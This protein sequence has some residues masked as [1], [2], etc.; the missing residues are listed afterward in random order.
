MHE[1]IKLLFDTF[2]PDIVIE[3]LT[4]FMTQARIERIEQVLSKRIHRVHIAVESP[5]DVHNGL[6]MVRTAEAMGVTHVHFV[7]AL[8]KKGQGR[9][10]TRGT[11]KWAHLKRHDTLEA[12]VQRQ[13]EMLLA[14]ACVDGQTSVEDLPVERPICFLFGNENTG[15][16]D[17]AKNACDILY[18]VPM[19]GMVESYNLSVTAAL[20]LYD[21]LKRKRHYMGCDGDLAPEE[22]LIEKAQ[23]YIRSIG[24]EMARQILERNKNSPVE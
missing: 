22:Y 14:G 6:A 9:G 1:L 24:P 17:A 12:F 8:M 18:H 4:P 3:T 20:T 13:G 2:T 23:Y 7:Q 19:Y 15:L 10:T 21:F 16:T 5:Y 11:L